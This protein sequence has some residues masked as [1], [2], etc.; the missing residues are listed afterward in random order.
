MSVINRT[1][2]LLCV[3]S[4]CSKV[5]FRLCLCVVCICVTYLQDKVDINIYDKN[6]KTPLMLAIGRKHDKVIGY[7]RKELKQR[8]SFIPRID[9]W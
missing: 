5:I 2:V 3:D 1:V 7:L 9:T 8:N 6:G 4:V